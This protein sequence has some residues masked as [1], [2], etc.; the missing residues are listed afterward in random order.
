MMRGG[1]S[2]KVS[3]EPNLVY[4]AVN[5]PGQPGLEVAERD[6]SITLNINRVE[7]TQ[8]LVNSFDYTPSD[9]E[10]YHVV[11]TVKRMDDHGGR[12]MYLVHYQVAQTK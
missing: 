3:D 1:E 10:K 4:Q 6:G 5:S 9:E 11:T 2:A 8:S 12:P 7:S